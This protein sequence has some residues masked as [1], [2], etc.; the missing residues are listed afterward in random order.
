[1]D[2]DFLSSAHELE[3][4]LKWAEAA[5]LYERILEKTP[6]VDLYER[7]AWCFSRA[8]VYQKA[9]E[10]LIILHEREPFSAKWLYMIGYQYYCK[11]EWML[12]IEWFERALAIYPDYFVVKYRL[13]Y[14]YIQTAGAYMKL[15]KAEYWKAIG[16][17]K[18]CHKLWETFDD[19]KKQRE[20]NTYFD[21]NFLNGKILMDL[22]RHYL[23]AISLFKKALS[24]K[25]ND[26]FA[27]YNL[28]KTYYL[29]GDYQ[30]AIANIPSGNQYYVVELTAYTEAKLGN[31]DRAISLVRKLLLRRK[32]DYLYSFLAEVYLLKNDLDEAYK[33]INEA[34]LIGKAN[35][36]N[37]YIA[38]KVYYQYGLLDKA[39]ENLDRG[40][41]LKRQ[42]YDSSYTDCEELK[43]KIICERPVDYEDD[44][45]LLGRL[46]K[47]STPQSMQGVIHKYNTEKGY[48]FIKQGT[49][50]IFFHIS[51]CK[52][53]EIATGDK[54]LFLTTDTDKGLK[55][56]DVIKVTNKK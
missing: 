37:V 1:M 52:Y 42:K 48:G 11:K 15:T 18:D 9:I 46:R 29:S 5:T 53:R 13:A 10:Y 23:E 34:L 50:D 21:V 25:P 2:S 27:N 54:V 56:I 43:Q 17:L 16:H 20:R 39:I 24:I 40:I 22:P 31:Y 33:A 41:K 49:K 30:N 7:A 6:S 3:K 51:D 12:A 36:K 32:K 28:A 26:E 35:H 47:I 19:T 45:C 44:Q 4:E 14:A 38:A 55:A 8:G